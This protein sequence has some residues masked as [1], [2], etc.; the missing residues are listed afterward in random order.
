LDQLLAEYHDKGPGEKPAS[1]G[2]RVCKASRRAHL[3]TW[4]DRPD[5]AD[6]E[7]LRDRLFELAQILHNLESCG[8]Y[9]INVAKRRDSVNNFIA[10][11]LPIRPPNPTRK[12]SDLV[13]K[14]I[15]EKLGLAKSRSR[16][17]AEL[18]L[19]RDRKAAAAG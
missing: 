9:E 16:K 7:V 3:A 10:G 19:Q 13:Q 14:I 8:I 5:K 6:A 15:D 11:D 12:E 4:M 17:C 1:W 2:Y 18:N